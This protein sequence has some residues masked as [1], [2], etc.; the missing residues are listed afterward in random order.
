MA[1]V[2]LSNA[3]LEAVVL[4]ERGG[5]LAAFNWIGAGGPVP[6]MR[7]LAADVTAPEPNQ[8]ACYPLVPWSNRIGHGRFDFEGKT[9][10]VA[11]NTVRDP[12][13]IHGDGWLSSWRVA[14]HR[15][16]LLALEL[17]RTAG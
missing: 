5:S 14:E 12:Y 1:A 11:P 13:P 4:P 6:L 7:P 9:F 8:L 2:R 15:A 10:R 3:L 16:D 17:D